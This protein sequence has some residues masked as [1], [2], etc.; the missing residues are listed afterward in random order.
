MQGAIAR[1]AERNDGQNLRQRFWH[2]AALPH[3]EIR[4]AC[5]SRACYKPHVHPTFSIGAVDG[6]SSIFTGAGGTPVALHPGALVFVPAERVHACNPAIDSAW[7]YQMMHLDSAW[8]ASVRQEY[9][10][11]S[12]KHTEPVRVVD[13][14]ALYTQFCALSDVLF[15]HAAVD[16]KE[17]ALIEFVGDYDLKQSSYVEPVVSSTQLEHSLAP[18]LETMRNAP[19]VTVALPELAARA[20]MSRYQLIRA[21]RAV[22]GMT[23]HAWQLNLRINVART[24]MHKGKSIAAVAHHLG[25]ADQAH[26]QRV[27]KAY[28]GVTPGSF[29]G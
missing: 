2:D 4:R 16:E 24:L 9:A 14:P 7:S 25:F 21:F 5:H 20:G 8:L 22:T 13:D 29:K 1:V 12:S 18:V 10:T 3:V 17:A 27:F 15:S 11:V 6:G 23:P 19:E 26:F 28:T